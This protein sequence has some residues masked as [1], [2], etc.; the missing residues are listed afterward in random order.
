MHVKAPYVEGE[1]I[2]DRLSRM[3]QGDA[4]AGAEA[5]A[6]MKRGW[7]ELMAG[8]P[9]EVSEEEKRAIAIR[10]YKETGVQRQAEIAAFGYDGGTATRKV[11][12]YLIEEGLL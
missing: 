9:G 1:W 4:D 6:S 3:G 7:G 10:V 2:F 8:Q 11:K 5:L 12:Q